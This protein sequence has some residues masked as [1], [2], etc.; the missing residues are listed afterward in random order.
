MGAVPNVC[1]LLVVFVFLS[2]SL[3]AWLV[4][5][6]RNVFASAE[7]VGLSALVEKDLGL[8][9]KGWRIT[10]LRGFRA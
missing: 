10:G 4:S 2:V 3:R 7:I 9:V 5:G 8:R 1:P 6:V